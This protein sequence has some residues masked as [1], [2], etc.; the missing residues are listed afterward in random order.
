[1][2]GPGKKSAKELQGELLDLRRE[3]LRLRM[4]QAAGQLSQ[5][6]LLRQKRREVARI[7]TAINQGDDK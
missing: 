3:Q 6:H 7:K 4:Q 1:M 5:P 2:A